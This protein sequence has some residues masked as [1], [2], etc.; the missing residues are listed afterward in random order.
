MKKI[1]STLLILSTSALFASPEKT[2][3]ETLTIQQEQLL[4]YLEKSLQRASQEEKN[5]AKVENYN[6]N[7]IENE[8]ISN[9]VMY[10]DIIS[11]IKKEDY[12]PL[13]K[14][15]IDARCKII[16]QVGRDFDLIDRNLTTNEKNELKKIAETS[17]AKIKEASI[18]KLK[19]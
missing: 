9:K 19:K 1:L 12:E 10:E 16:K 5:K 7:N 2:I 18:E 17:N 13:K 15:Y 11:N 4:P 6:C 14:R 8:L 3:F